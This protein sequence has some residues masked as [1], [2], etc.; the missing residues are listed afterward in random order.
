[1]DSCPRPLPPSIARP[2]RASTREAPPQR[3]SHSKTRSATSEA[4]RALRPEYQTK[5]SPSRDLRYRQERTSVLLEP[6][7]FRGGF[8]QKAPLPVQ[9][10]SRQDRASTNR[11]SWPTSVA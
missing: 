9:E 10:I 11:A 4:P 8:R 3:A 6:S 7:L 1:L 2:H 5:R